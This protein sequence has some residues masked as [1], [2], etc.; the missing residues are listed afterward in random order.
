MRRWINLF[1]DLDFVFEPDIVYAIQNGKQVGWFSYDFSHAANSE[2]SVHSSIDSAYRRQGIASQAYD[3]IEAHLR[4]DGKKLVPNDRLSHEAYQMWLKRDP[5]A[6][7][8]YREGSPSWG[9]RLYY[10]PRGFAR[11][12]ETPL[13]GVDFSELDMTKP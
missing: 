9:M 4:G 5:K 10:S 7:R 6:V 1:E 8:A 13:N 12:G 11:F 3:A 2:I